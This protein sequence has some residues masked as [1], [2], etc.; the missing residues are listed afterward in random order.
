[1]AFA[2]VGH[3]LDPVP[4]DFLAKRQASA[5]VVRMQLRIKDSLLRLEK[6]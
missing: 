3:L 4:Y 1:L 2:L 6:L 5:E